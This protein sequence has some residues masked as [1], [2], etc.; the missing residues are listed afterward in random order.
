MFLILWCYLKLF[1]D[2]I[3]IVF[4]WK[5]KRNSPSKA[6]SKKFDIFFKNFHKIKKTYVFQVE[7]NLTKKFFEKNNLKNCDSF[8]I[9]NPEKG[10]FYLFYVHVSN[11]PMSAGKTHFLIKNE[12]FLILFCPK[13]PADFWKKQHFMHFL[14]PP[15]PAQNI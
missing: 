1:F 9:E 13:L 11:P 14:I 8:P 12:Y 2:K 5:P 7:K 4:W 10:I 6:C 15:R 3:F